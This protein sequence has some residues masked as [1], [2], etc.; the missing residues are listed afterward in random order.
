MVQ[1]KFILKHLH[2]EFI[3][4]IN[5]KHIFLQIKRI[6]NNTINYLYNNIKYNGIYAKRLY[7]KK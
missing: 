2:N 4:K 3:Q 1:K 7:L 5:S 6:N